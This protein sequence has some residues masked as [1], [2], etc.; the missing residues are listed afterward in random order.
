MAAV[1]TGIGFTICHFDPR[2]WVAILLVAAILG[3][4]RATSGSLWPSLAAHVGF[5]AVTIVGVIVAWKTKTDGVELTLQQELAGSGLLVAAL[6]AFVALARVAS[7]TNAAR[8]N[9]ERIG[10]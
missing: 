10:D 4:L 5:N 3:L 2:Q 6:V 1:V 9:E 7:S 8:R